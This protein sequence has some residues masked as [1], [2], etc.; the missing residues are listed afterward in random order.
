MLNY[1]GLNNNANLIAAL[2]GKMKAPWWHNNR[3]AYLVS[4]SVC[5][6]FAQMNEALFKAF[7]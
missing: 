7:I 3:E 1:N 6:Y 4:S 2:D 5:L